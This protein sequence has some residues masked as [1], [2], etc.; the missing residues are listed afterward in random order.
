MKFLLLLL[1]LAYE[2]RA[3]APPAQLSPQDATQLATRM[4]QL[5]ESTAVAI[6]DLIAASQ[7]VKQNADSIFTQL[8]RT[9]LDPGLTWRFMSQIKAY[10]AL[11]ESFPR[12]NPF[13]AA[14][15]QQLMELR[16][17]LQ[18]LQQ[19]FE[20]LLVVQ[21]QT[22]QKLDSD[23]NNL[24]RYAEADSKMLPASQSP[25]V[26]FLGDSITDAWRLNEYFTGRDFVNRGISGQTSQQMLGRFRQD[27]VA[28]NPKAVVILGGTNDIAAGISVN[29][30]EENMTM[31]GDLARV[32]NIKPVFASILPVSDYHKDVDPAYAVTSTRPL[33]TIQAVNKWIQTYCQS[34]GFVY[35]DYYSATVDSSGQLKADLSDDGLHPNAKGY[36][37]MSPIA[38]EAINRALPTQ[39][40][41]A[42]ASQS[43]RRNR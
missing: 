15:D 41:G 24:Q 17:D 42:D 23:P 40:S 38:L 28:L 6:P 32:H 5:M 19:H 20:S 25:R 11:A 34:Q 12:P 29:Q 22:A 31:L 1:C 26:V 14:A 33:A 9:P 43:K 10:L 37:V 16:S 7:P 30:I 8:Q 39:P 36:R 4:L 3:Q 21:N 35:L 2:V 13:P 27:V 18:R